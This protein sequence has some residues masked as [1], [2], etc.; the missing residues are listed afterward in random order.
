MSAEDARLDPMRNPM[1]TAAS[2]AALAAAALLAAPGAAALS[3]CRPG[4]KPGAGAGGGAAAAGEA[5]MDDSP[6]EPVREIDGDGG[7]WH[8]KDPAALRAQVLGFLDQAKTRPPAAP[9]LAL[10]GPHAGYVYSGP[11]A[12]EAYAAVR[13]A[14]YDTVFV[15]GTC[16]RR[17]VDGVS[18]LA[19]GCY[20]TP[21]GHLNV[22]EEAAAAM[23]RHESGRIR[24]VE[25]AHAGEHSVLNQLPFLQVAL[26]P[27]FRI[28]PALIRARDPDDLAVLGQAI[29][30]AA[31]GKRALVVASTDLS[32][33][34][35]HDGA[36][37]CDPEILAA[38]ATMDAARLLAK[39]AEILGKGIEGLDC[40]MCGLDA[41][42]AALIAAQSMGA[43]EARVLDVR[44]SF[45]TARGDPRRVVGYGAMVVLGG[46]E[47]GMSPDTKKLLL[48]IA[49][50][51]AQASLEGR[52][53][54]F[55]PKD[56]LPAEARGKGG[57]FV[58]LRNEHMAETLRGCIGNYNATGSREL[59]EVVAEMGV[60]ATQDSRFRYDPLTADEMKNRVRVEISVLSP[61][62]RVRDP[63]AI[64][65]GTHGVSLVWTGLRRSVYLPQ[66]ATETGWDLE[67][68]LENLCEKGGLPPDA[69]R[70]GKR[71]E[72]D[73]FTAEVFSD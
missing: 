4:A 48:G 52:E 17:P 29:A 10:V 39:D 64:R 37:A 19:K 11:V 60:A 38:A 54:A 25:E 66:V 34:P 53:P 22:D 15:L 71:M 18:V 55:P 69:W 8:P 30:A 62:T 9:V 16:H 51:A 21:L 44:D 73:L 12:A 46:K 58:T 47:R 40:T 24:T 61:F 13:G 32:H 43:S 50:E 65:L 70:D 28:V 41:V 68:F 33:F 3:G 36:K 20:R 1:S 45:E 56:S 23:L 26:A 72:F 14:S 27:P 63:S 67:T 5:K 2:C 57:A 6:R 49:R 31:A 35:S 59:W 42:A 7:R